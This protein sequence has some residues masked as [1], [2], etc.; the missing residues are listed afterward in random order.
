MF[1][2]SP[3]S[4]ITKLIGLCC[5]GVFLATQLNVF[6]HVQGMTYAMNG[7]DRQKD[8]LADQ[9]IIVS[10]NTMD[11]NRKIMSSAYMATVKQ[12]D[13]DAYRN[14]TFSAQVPVK[15]LLQDGESRPEDGFEGV[16]AESR[17]VFYAQ[18]ECERLL[19]TMASS[20][21]VV[22]ATGKFKRDI[23]D[24]SAVLKFTQKAAFGELDATTAWS[25]NEVQVNMT[26]GMVTSPR[27]YAH[28]KRL[29]FYRKAASE[30]TQIKRRAGNCAITNIRIS[31]F[32]ES[33]STMVKM[34]ASAEYG[35]LMRQR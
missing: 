12:D 22:R 13:I 35:F 15:Q 14:V 34:N 4:M 33:N 20:C 30:C 1:D 7:G 31:S 21:Q 16:F 27:Q 28:K 32:Q 2:N 11:H 5:F 24:I 26:D 17:A 3:I 8:P 10:N 29:Q 6:N 19:Q 23:V 9:G 25:F 18:E